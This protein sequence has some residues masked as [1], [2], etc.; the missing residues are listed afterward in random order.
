MIE[1]VALPASPP[2]G[3]TLAPLI[4]E[5]HHITVVMAGQKVKVDRY[6]NLVIETAK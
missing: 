4:A 2:E 5:P 1:G 3:A 6:R